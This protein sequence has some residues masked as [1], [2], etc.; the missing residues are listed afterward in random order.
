[1]LKQIVSQLAGRMGYTIVPN[2]QLRHYPG[3]R[4]TQRLFDLLGIDLVLD[5][6]ANAGQFRDFLRSQVGYGGRIVSFEPTPRLAEALAARA[7]ADPLWSVEPRALGAVPGTAAFHVMEN[8]EFS[9]FLT[10]RH[11]STGLFTEM[12]RVRET[13]D[14]EVATLDAVLPA[15]MAQHRAGAVYLKLDTQGFD[16]EAIKGAEASLPH[17]AALQTEAS[18][19]PI[20]QGAPSYSDVTDHLAA[21]GFV[22]SG[23][24]P[25]NEG[26]FPELIEFDCLMIRADRVPRPASDGAEG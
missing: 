6:G 15:L 21:R 17:I 19:R 4:H 12:N 24:F 7:A 25:N 9:S 22:V 11:D 14:V 1:M 5:V 10:P 18:V 2:W 16:L 13:V 23:M 26:N 3:M 20:Y 8:S